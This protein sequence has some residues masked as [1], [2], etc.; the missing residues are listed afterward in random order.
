[1]LQVTPI[2]LSC[3]AMVPPVGLKHV[4]EWKAYGHKDCPGNVPMYSKINTVLDACL[5]VFLYDAVQH[6]I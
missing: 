5:Y 1:M 3:P 4:A 2:E 6:E